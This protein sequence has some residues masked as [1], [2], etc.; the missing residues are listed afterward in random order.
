MWDATPATGSATSGWGNRAI[1]VNNQYPWSIVGTTIA[2]HRAALGAMLGSS[3]RAGMQVELRQELFAFNAEDLARFVLPL[4]LGGAFTNLM[5]AGAYLVVADRERGIIQKLRS[6]GLDAASYWSGLYLGDVVQTLP[7]LVVTVVALLAI[8]GDQL[9][10]IRVGGLVLLLLEYSLA[11]SALS[12]LV[13]SFIPTQEM[14][15][16]I[17][18]V[19]NMIFGLGLHVAVQL[20]Y[21][22]GN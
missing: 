10:G 3:A 16:A 6:L 13:A 4:L 19:M 22:S 8:D 12:Y 14:A 9:N 1:A 7:A 18:P 17:I 21:T 2:E 15:G 20:L 11:L 5:Q